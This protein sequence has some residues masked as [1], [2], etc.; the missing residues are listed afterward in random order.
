MYT[1]IL[2]VFMAWLILFGILEEVWKQNFEKR[3]RDYES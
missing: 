1:E 3:V 2:L